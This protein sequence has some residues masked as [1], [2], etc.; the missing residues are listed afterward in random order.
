MFRIFFSILLIAS[1]LSTQAQLIINEVLYDPS[2][3]GLDGDANGDGVY[4]QTQDEFIE[5][6]N[7]SASD[8]NISRY[9]ILDR[10]IGT[11]VTTV[12]HRMDSNL[13]IPAGGCVVVFGGGAAA[14][15]FGGAHVEVD[16]G[17]TGL[18]MGNTGE[19]VLIADSS[20][21]ILDSLDTDALSNNPDESYTRNPD[22]EGNTFAQHAAVTTNVLFSPGT[23]ADGNPFNTVMFLT[24]PL[25]NNH[26]ICMGSDQKSFSIVGN[27][28]V[29]FPKQILDSK[30]N[31]V[32]ILSVNETC[33][34][35]EGYPA[36][37]Y[38]LR[39]LAP[40]RMTL[41]FILN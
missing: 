12:R 27:S 3:T 35:M 33:F 30:G 10:V 38:S 34:S 1:S 11:G 6:V 17:T 19:R 25:K 4:D 7:R 21:N 9:Q 8:L 2:N 23:K 26:L 28:P 32:K 36:G 31:C 40:K 37:V 20:G 13:V 5:I 24:A 41:K 14:G 22:V 29:H 39:M 15:S 16:I 18:S